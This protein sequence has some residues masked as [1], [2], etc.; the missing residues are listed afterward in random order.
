MKTVLIAYVSRTGHTRK[1]AELIA[2]G[3]RFSGNS[4]EIRRSRRHERFAGSSSTS[5]PSMGASVMKVI[6]PLPKVVLVA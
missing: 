2:E 1:M 6:W 5:A 4:A 3:V